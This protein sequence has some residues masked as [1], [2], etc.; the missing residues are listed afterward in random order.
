MQSLSP[1]EIATLTRT[2]KTKDDDLPASVT[3]VERL[4]REIWSEVLGVSLCNVTY[5]AKFFS[6]GGDSI[7]AMQVV[8]ASRARG[9][10][11]TVRKV[12]ESQT[13]PKLAAQSQTRKDT[14]D[15]SR[16][17]EGVFA[18]SPIQQMYFDQIAPDGL[19][20][21]GEYHF[22]QGVSLH[23][24]KRVELPELAWALDE[25]VVK[26]AMLR[27]RFRHSQEHG[28]QQWIER[29]L[30]GSYRL[31]SHT[32]AD[33]KSVQHIV[34]Q[35]QGSLNLEHGP[36]FAAAQIEVQDRQVLHLVAH[37]LVIDLV[38]WRILIRDLG[39]LLE[40]RKLPNPSSLSF[41]VWLE[42]QYQSLS[43]FVSEIGTPAE[44][45]VANMLPVAV[46]SANWEY[47]CLTPGQNVWGSL[48]SIQTKLD[49]NTTSLLYNSANAALNTEPVEIML[50]AL[51]LSFRA[52]FTD[53]PVPAVFT[54]GHGREAADDETDLSDTIGW[55]TTMTPL[56]VPVGA[57]SDCSIDVLRQVKD[58]R[59][60]IPGR[61]VPYFGSRFLTARGREEF[62]GHGPAEILL[63][64]TGRFQQ[65]EREDTLF[66]IDDGD[67]S[68][69][70]VGGMVKTFAVLDVT[71]TVEADELCISLRFSRQV[72]Q[73]AA[74]QEWLQAY[75]NA[76]KSLVNELVIAASTAT[77]T[78]FPLARL[79]DNDMVAIE[80][81][82][83]NTMGL[84]STTYIE[85]ILPC[86][87]IQ[88]GI[89]LTQVQSP[90]IYYIQQTCYI[91]SSNLANP[92][93]M[94]RLVN[95]WHHVVLQ[96]TILQT[97]LLESLS[98]QERFI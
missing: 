69:S 40:H 83:L 86:S 75:G 25:A 62:A 16:V 14:G 84:S 93:S 47:W 54:E 66:R 95:A 37:H 27:A 71:V 87:P 89:L 82:Y 5:S 91:K 48:A 8:S 15:A 46:P 28:W 4:L 24:T 31:S 74:V 32:A 29:E 51:F 34:A 6:L 59:R 56:H 17:P 30:I 35:S 96:H 70:D 58:Q 33:A 77:A 11:I 9:I 42:R 1:N 94:E 41:P 78:D 43:R 90:S 55:F 63:N 85:D 26:H 44:A 67:Y 7:I 50:A 57:N 79:S 53:R 45:F 52:V 72:R 22:N 3:I 19:R 73:Q 92:V 81:K 97:I 36:V 65:T 68:T 23:I 61:G 60:R 80:G 98:S 2:E 10:L 21:E 18:L 49:S 76:M 39:E 13:I 64:Y 38:S 88:Q 20:T 12:L